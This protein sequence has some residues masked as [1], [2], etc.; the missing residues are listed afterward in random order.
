M[1]QVTEQREG[2]VVPPPHQ[3]ATVQQPAQRPAGQRALLLPVDDTDVSN[4]AERT[5]HHVDMKVVDL[6]ACDHRNQSKLASGQPPTCTGTV[7]RL[8][9]SDRAFPE[10]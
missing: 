10:K 6:P 9:P 1:S 3:V 7:R 8:C 4:P 2:A 5:L